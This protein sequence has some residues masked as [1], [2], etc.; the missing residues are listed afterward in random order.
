MLQPK[1]QRACSRRHFDGLTREQLDACVHDQAKTAL[2]S[3]SAG[4]L[5]QA[6]RCLE[7][8]GW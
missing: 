8:G 5:E 3:L 2:C 4:D 1:R 7:Q 6:E